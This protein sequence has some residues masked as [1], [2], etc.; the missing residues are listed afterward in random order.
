MKRIL[1]L[2]LTI[3]V[4]FACISALASCRDSVV[5]KA[6]ESFPNADPQ[7]AKDALLENGYNAVL[8]DNGLPEGYVA[9]LEAVKGQDF[10][11]ITYYSDEKL[12]ET[13][14]ES[15]QGTIE[16]IRS[17]HASIVG[18]SKEDVIIKKHEKMVFIGTSQAI[19][20]TK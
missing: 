4:L 15:I 2:T 13:E 14:W 11:L 10:I 17:N 16:A 19:K 1:S 12:L 18:I 5:E 8:I 6:E 3:L 7:K 9:S 20:D